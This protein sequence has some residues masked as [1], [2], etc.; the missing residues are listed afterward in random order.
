MGERFARLQQ[1]GFAEWR[2]AVDGMVFARSLNVDVLDE[3]TSAG[4]YEALVGM[5]VDAVGRGQ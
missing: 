1:G 3:A 5:T 2:L 4:V